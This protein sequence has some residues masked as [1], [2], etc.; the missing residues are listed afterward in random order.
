MLLLFFTDFVLYPS[1]VINHSCAY[2]YMLNS[3][4]TSSESL[5][6]RVISGTPDTTQGEEYTHTHPHTCVCVYTHWDL[7]LSSCLYMR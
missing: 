5:N 2:V 1:T 3:V 6:L 4:S 7:R